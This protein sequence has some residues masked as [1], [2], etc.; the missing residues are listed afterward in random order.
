[1]SRC[2][3]CDNPLLY[4]E[5]CS[6]CDGPKEKSRWGIGVL[7]T[8]A[9]LIVLGLFISFLTCFKRKNPVR[10]GRDAPHIISVLATTSS[11]EG[12]GTVAA[13]ERRGYYHFRQLDDDGFRSVLPASKFNHGKRV[14]P[15]Y[16]RRYSKTVR[17]VDGGTVRNFLRYEGLDERP[18]KLRRA[19]QG[20]NTPQA[21]FP[22]S[23]SGKSMAATERNRGQSS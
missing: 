9:L 3:I 4:G 16:P 1:M 19:W 13:F 18:P 5:K 12:R 2:K 17:L 11:E 14:F 6:Y 8:A 10:G 23:R 15:P 21:D 7:G 20:G 22:V